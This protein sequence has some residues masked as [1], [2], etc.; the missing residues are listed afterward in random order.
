MSG[1]EPVPSAVPC[2]PGDTDDHL[3][4]E[5]TPAD[6]SPLPRSSPPKPRPSLHGI[7]GVIL[8]S[9]AFTEINAGLVIVLR[10]GHAPPL[11]LPAPTDKD[12]DS[13]ALAT[14][15]V[16]AY[17]Q[18]VRRLATSRPPECLRPWNKNAVTTWTARCVKFLMTS[19]GGQFTMG[20]YGLILMMKLKDPSLHSP[21]TRC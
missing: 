5:D 11:S 9:E 14:Q 3:E 7:K 21:T 2:S 1:D 15:V 19:A 18:D 17:H 8:V 6:D 20:L 13:D 10:S 16:E 12:R 4:Q